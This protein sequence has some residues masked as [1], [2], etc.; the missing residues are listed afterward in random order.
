MALDKSTLTSTIQNALLANL[1]Q[2]DADAAALSAAQSAANT[3]GTTIANA[4]DAF[5]KSGTVAFS[6]GSVTGGTPANGTLTGG[7]ATGGIIS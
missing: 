1:N 7:S 4:I 2:G 3:L 5:V 6:S